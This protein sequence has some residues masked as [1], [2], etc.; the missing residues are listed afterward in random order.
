[1]PAA[2][3]ATVK[4]RN[5]DERR[6]AMY[7][8]HSEEIR[9]D[10]PQLAAGVMYVRGIEGTRDVSHQV[11]SL[12]ESTRS[13]YGAAPESTLPEIQAW[14]RAFTSMGLKPTQYRSAAESLLRRFRKE[15]ALPPLHPL[16]DLCN[17]VSLLFATPIAVFD[18]AKIA[19]YLEVRRALGNEIYTPFSGPDEAPEVGE[20]VFVDDIGRAHARR[21]THRQSG[22]SAVGPHTSSALIVAEAL[23]DTAAADVRAVIDVLNPLVSGIAQSEIRWAILRAVG[24]RFDFDG[25]TFPWSA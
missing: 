23:H 10:F 2:I 8:R 6:S 11:S 13:K 4:N 15:D 9:H 21:W 20:V 18:S 3:P 25:E 19:G 22:F 17:G 16:V 12:W 5:E 7:F 1:M 24:E 14:R